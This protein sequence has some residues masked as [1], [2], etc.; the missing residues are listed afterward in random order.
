ME[1]DDVQDGKEAKRESA[2]RD[3]K[4]LQRLW[5]SLSPELKETHMRVCL[6]VGI[7]PE[8]RVGLDSRGFVV[9][10]EPTLPR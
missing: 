8:R 6:A 10:V 4:G 2:R 7:N 9:T 1:K 5:A 3:W